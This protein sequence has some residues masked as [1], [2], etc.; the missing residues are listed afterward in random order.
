MFG[1]KSSEQ[2]SNLADQTAQSAEQVIRSTQ[3]VANEALESLSGSVQDMRQQAAPVLNRVGE[4]A[5]ALVRHGVD[6][7]RD[8]SRQLREN[9]LHASDSTVKY[10]KDEPVKAILIAAATGAALMALI[11][12]MNRSSGRN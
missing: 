2:T 7:V 9:A 10:I 6:S 4:Q 1:T 8:T 5:S 11:G 3:R 12:L